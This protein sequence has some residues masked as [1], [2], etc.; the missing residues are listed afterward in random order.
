MKLIAFNCDYYSFYFTLES[1]HHCAVDRK[2]ERTPLMTIELPNL[3]YA[4]EAL[5]PVISRT[6]LRTHHGKHHR[7]YVDKLNALVRGTR[8]AGNSVEA[9]VRR[10]DRRRA[11]DPAMVA[12][13]NNA[14]QAWNHAFYWRSLRP[15]GGP[16]PKG[17]LATRIESDFG[18]YQAFA[19]S[20]KAAAIG[21]FGSGWAWLVLD[22]EILKI[23]TT[24]NADTPI[25]HGQAPLLLIDVW[26]H[27]YYLDYQERR[28]AY[29][30]AVVDRL[31]DWDFAER[32]FERWGGWGDDVIE[33]CG[34]LLG[35]AAIERALAGHA[36]VA[37]A[38][39]VGYPHPVKG[40]GI[41][42]YV[43]PGP[44]VRPGDKLRREL[45]QRVGKEVGPNAVPEVIQWVTALP[46]SRVGTLVR[47]ILRKIAANDGSN[48]GDTSLLVDPAVIDDLISSRPD[49]AT[50]TE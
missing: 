49:M 14:A 41:Y 32:N 2:H 15:G 24:P 25:A 10:A 38:A 13:F 4:Y 12:V 46:K 43:R 29:V 28:A 26:E 45:E 31:L 27:A 50:S 21:H 36:A 34:S 3:P 23:I 11:V 18:S 42:A 7:G 47:D 35:T 16:G 30:A 44:G 19:E 37:E 8:L 20:F 33:V 9:I 5:E 17:A 39:V 6:T 40:Q 48:L 1:I 22:Q